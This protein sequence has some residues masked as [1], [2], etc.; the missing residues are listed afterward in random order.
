MAYKETPIKVKWQLHPFYSCD[1][2]KRVQSV[3]V[4]NERLNKLTIYEPRHEK[5]CLRDFPTRS[6]T[7]RVV[8]ST[9]NYGLGIL[10]L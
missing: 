3:C 9:D 4:I 7:N 10:G 2:L 1:A 6:D 8:E 5:T